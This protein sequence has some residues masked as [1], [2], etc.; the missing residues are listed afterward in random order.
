MLQRR[1]LFK[2]VFFGAVRWLAFMGILTSAIARPSTALAAISTAPQLVAPSDGSTVSTF[3]PTLQWSNPA[4][5]TQYHLQVI[6]VNNDGPGVNLIIGS[7]G[8]SFSIPAPPNWYGL[9]PDM[10]YTWQVRVTDATV[11][12]AENDSRWGPWSSTWAFRTPKTSSGSL[13]LGSPVGDALVSSITPVLT[14]S[15]SDPAIYYYEVQVS[16]DSAF[17]T[18]PATAVASVYWEMRHGG[19]TAPL[20][21]YS[22][23][24]SSPLDAGTTYYWRVR[25]RVQGD[26][27]PVAWSPAASFKTPS[28]TAL[29]LQ[30]TSP[31]DRSVVNIPSIQVTGKT[32]PGAYVTANDS[33]VQAGGDGTFSASVTLVEGPNI[34]DVIASSQAGEVVSVTLT[35]TY[36]P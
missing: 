35:V 3:G 25:P 28:A 5:T 29:F 6:P 36:I 32:Q 2:L 14:W 9:L 15:S 10:R 8:A 1:S 30:V 12:L 23:S 24:Q 26:G 11:S 34:I 17:N 19:V 21:S 33:F 4:G 7:V 18:D 13:T 20:N 27:S 31:A 22:V 16:R